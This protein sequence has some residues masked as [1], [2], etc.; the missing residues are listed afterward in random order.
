MERANGHRGT[1]AS[2]FL[3]AMAV[4]GPGCKRAPT[5]LRVLV[6]TDFVP[7]ASMPALHS[8]VLRVRRPGANGAVLREEPITLARDGSNLPL[9]FSVFLTSAPSDQVVI[10]AEA[11]TL[12][13]LSRMD[14]M[15]GQVGVPVT[16]SRVITG[17]VAGEIRVVPMVLYRG[18]WDRMVACAPDQS[19]GPQARCES[20]QRDPSTLPTYNGDAGDPLDVFTPASEAS[21]PM[22]ASA[23]A[24]TVDAGRDVTVM[25]DRFVPP[26]DNVVVMPPADGG[27]CALMAPTVR[28]MPLST[29]TAVEP[30]LVDLNTRPMVMPT[31]LEV[32]WVGPPMGMPMSPMQQVYTVGLTRMAGMGGTGSFLVQ[33]AVNPSG[34]AL[35]P[36]PIRTLSVPRLVNDVGV[37]VLAEGMVPMTELAIVGARVDRAMGL[38]PAT[39][40]MPPME[41]AR[42]AFGYQA[43][44]SA[45]IPVGMG[46]DGANVLA[47]LGDTGAA[48]L[49]CAYIEPGPGGTI[50]RRTS[51]VIDHVSAMLGPG[52][53]LVAMAESMGAVQ[54]ALEG[55]GMSGGA[56]ATCQA[57]MPF[58]SM[59][60][61]VSA[62]CNVLR[63]SSGVV[64]PGS[65]SAQWSTGLMCGG[66][67]MAVAGWYG[68]LVQ[69]GASSMD[70]LR[71]GRIEGMNIEGLP[72]QWSVPMAMAVR[73]GTGL[74]PAPCE[75]L[76]AHGYGDSMDLY[77]ARLTDRAISGRFTVPIH[78]NSAIRVLPQ[79]PPG[80]GPGIDEHC[81]TVVDRAGVVQLLTI[82]VSNPCMMGMM[83]MGM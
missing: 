40:F 63:Q 9:K 31:A 73:T 54:F 57:T 61:S 32:A 24:T 56:I 83:P 6:T 2:V 34:N 72:A 5:G 75:M 53:R 58:P 47:C 27:A 44:N 10:E 74:A 30:S 70:V 43:K 76:V 55:S 29:G 45:I 15:T 1:T 16:T 79:A 7:S 42:P 60:G 49:Q 46:P 50:R 4:C 68:A 51:F 8:V 20:A 38:E 37:V 80:D 39:G 36:L 59:G 35:T 78:A 66:G 25:E 17:F 52:A 67:G 14:P 69:A 41:W 13:S 22:D 23:D 28:S 26:P 64:R 71:A 19:C 82:S 11:H 48:R 65:F 77:R 12:E 3:A 81:M 21:V 62:T 33:R 18:C